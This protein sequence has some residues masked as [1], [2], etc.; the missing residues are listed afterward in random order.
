MKTAVTSVLNKE[1][2]SKIRK[3][4]I[5]CLSKTAVERTG[6]SFPSVMFYLRK[7]NC[8]SVADTEMPSHIYTW[9]YF[10]YIMKPGACEKCYV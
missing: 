8:I 3:T 4:I 10:D 6:V 1:K 9:D 7:E 5:R 2:K